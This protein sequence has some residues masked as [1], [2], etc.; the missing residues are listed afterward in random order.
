MKKYLISFILISCFSPHD[1]LC[2]NAY[3]MSEKETALSLSSHS[4]RREKETP[5]LEEIK[6]RTYSNIPNPANPFPL[7][8]DKNLCFINR[9]ITNP[10]II[11]GDYSY[12]YDPEDVF[13]FEKNVL[14]HFAILNDK[15]IIGK[16]CQIGTNVKFIMNGGN[17]RF[18]G[19]SSFPFQAFGGDW[20][21]IPT[22]G[23]IKGNT[24][25]GNDVW[26]GYGA[27]IMP[28]VSIGDGVIIGALSC[29]T[30]NIEPYTIVGGN[31]AKT[32]RKRFDEET[33]SFLLDLKWWNWPIEKVTQFATEIVTGER[34]KLS[35]L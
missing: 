9:I 3:A 7:K 1:E 35:T 27:T 8:E 23:Q 28:G 6:E 22:L 19:Y 12:Y 18:E 21:S 13:N 24:I 5:I 34:S 26:I 33:I 32:I 30:K 10:N 25:I 16:F 14:Y 29:V 15:L 17:H 4:P 2:S 31:P 20:S 11:A